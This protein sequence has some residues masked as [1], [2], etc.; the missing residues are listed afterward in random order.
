MQKTNTSESDFSQH[1]C[2]R[3]ERE[4]QAAECLRVGAAERG[5]LLPLAVKLTG[6]AEDGMNLYQQKLL[7]CH[8]A[9]Q[10][11]G[12]KGSNYKFYILQAIKWGAVEERRRAGKLTP[13][14]LA[15]A[16]DRQLNSPAPPEDGLAALA[17]DVETELATGYHPADVT[18]FRLHVAGSTYRQ[19]GQLTGKDYSWIR[20]TIVKMKNELRDTF[21]A[22]FSN[23]SESE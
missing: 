4:A 1:E 13:L 9:I 3:E 19:I 22:A 8:D 20:R 16:Y 6:S 10:Q 14:E 17:A 21:G 23:L 5:H 7:D 12:F 15:E 18:A 11:E 2:P